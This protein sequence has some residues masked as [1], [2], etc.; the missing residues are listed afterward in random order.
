MK[1][2]DRVR[3]TGHGYR[4][5]IEYRY[6]ELFGDKEYKVIDVRRSCCNT[7]VVLEGIDGMYCEVFFSKA[8]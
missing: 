3:F 1:I 7:F 2:G 5:A 4:R 6:E 8:G